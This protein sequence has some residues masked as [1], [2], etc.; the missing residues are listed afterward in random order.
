LLKETT[1]CPW[2]RLEIFTLYIWYSYMFNSWG[3]YCIIFK[4]TSKS[5]PV[6]LIGRMF[7]CESSDPGLIPSWCTLVTFLLIGHLHCTS[8]LACTEVTSSKVKAT[9]TDDKLLDGLPRNNE[10]VELC[11]GFFNVVYCCDPEWKLP[12]PPPPHTSI[13]CIFYMLLN[14]LTYLKSVLC[15]NYSSNEVTTRSSFIQFLK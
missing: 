3:K 11:S 15:L 7:Y 6:S 14:L 13:T 2:Q 4:H 9:S 1:T 5:C 12:T 10:V 8:A